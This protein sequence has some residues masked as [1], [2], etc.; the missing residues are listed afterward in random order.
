MGTSSKTKGKNVIGTKC[1]FINKLNKDGHA[2]R[3]KDKLVCK[4]YAQDEGID[5]EE[6]FSLVSRMEAQ[7]DLG[8]CMLQ[9]NKIISYGY[10][11]NISKWGITRR[12]LCRATRK[13]SFIK[14]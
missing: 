6:S 10:K 12:S 8:I 14:T 3:N 7:N 2:R 1:V 9:I 11:I 5:F 13:I 4:G